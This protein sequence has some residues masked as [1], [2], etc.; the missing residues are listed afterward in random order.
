MKAV[1]VGCGAISQEW[2]KGAADVPDL[3]LVG[4]VDLLAANAEKRRTE[5]AP[6][7]L[8]GTDLA[9]MLEQTKPDVVFD[10]TVPAA[11]FGVVTT[12]LEHGCHVLGEKPMADTLEQAHLMIQKAQAAGKLFVVM[13][14]WR[15]THNIRRLKTFLDTTPIGTLTGLNADFYIG[16]HFGGFREEMAHVLLKDMAIHTFDAAR[17]LT[18]QAAKSV[19]AAEWNPKGSWYAQDA[20][21]HAL[22]DMAES[23]RFSYRGSWCA[24]GFRTPWE[25]AWRIIGT[26]GS[27]L[28]DGDAD[29]RCEVIAEASTKDDDSF[30]REYKTILIPDYPDVKKR[31]ERHAAVIRSFVES[32]KNGTTPETVCTDNIKSLAMVYGAV[33]SSER[34]EKVTIRS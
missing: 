7:A 6:D 11:H 8:I 19:Y 32:L 25:S 21:A 14:N 3:E 22:F 16:A 29:M 33:E 26:K 34:G 4:L 13:Q 28:W 18:G 23:V 20:A 5:Y 2:F 15:Y 24:E 30:L 31:P 17:F 10:C 1:L 12:A 9:A 27:I